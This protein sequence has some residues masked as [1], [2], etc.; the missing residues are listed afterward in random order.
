MVICAIFGCSKRSGRDKVSFFRIP[1]V[2][3][4]RN[5]KYSQLI[6]KRQKLWIARIKREDLEETKIKHARVCELHFIS[7]K[8]FIMVFFKSNFMPHTTFIIQR[9]AILNY[10]VV[11]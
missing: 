5:Y 2:D 3:M 10:S 4:K 11:A 7:G 6:L 8:Q 1:C 9:N